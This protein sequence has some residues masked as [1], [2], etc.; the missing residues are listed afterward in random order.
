MMKKLLSIVLVLLLAAAALSGCGG[1]ADNA[2]QE[3]TQQESAQNG[4]PDTEPANSEF[5]EMGD[6]L[7]ATYVDM[8]KNDQYLMKYKA[9]MDIEGQTMNVEATIAVSGDKSA[10][11]SSGNGFESF[12]IMKDGKVYMIDDASK[13]ITSWAQ[14]QNDQSEA[15]STDGLEYVGSGK[16]GGLVYEEYKTADNNVKYYFDGKDL[17]KISSVVEGQ[18]VVMEI[19]EM[20]N[21]VP[22]GM[23]EI[24]AGYQ[25]MEM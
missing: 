11:K 3:G 14:T 6:L 2:S 20:S 8:M 18:T 12:M 25:M 15:F 9:S 1:S 5:D 24:P 10:V 16:E 21:D 22:A 23:F 19:L 13:T 7:S 17:V 4:Q